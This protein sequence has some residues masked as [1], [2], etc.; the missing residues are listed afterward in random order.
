MKTILNEWRSFLAEDK[1]KKTPLEEEIEAVFAQQELKTGERLANVKAAA[2]AIQFLRGQQL[3]NQESYLNRQEFGMT[4]ADRIVMI[5]QDEN[6]FSEYFDIYTAV[7]APIDKRFPETSEKT[8]KAVEMIDTWS[9][10]NLEKQST[11][12]VRAKGANE[13]IAFEELFSKIGELEI[14]L[15]NKNYEFLKYFGKVSQWRTIEDRHTGGAASTGL[16]VLPEEATEEDKA[17]IGERYI[18]YMNHRNSAAYPMVKLAEEKF[19]EALK[20]ALSLWKQYPFKDAE[21]KQAYAGAVIRMQDALNQSESDLARIMMN[22]DEYSKHN[23]PEPK[24][25]DVES[26]IAKAKD[27]DKEAAKK[28]FDIL[29]NQGDKRWREMRQLM[30]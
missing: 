3:S 16:I 10:N 4:N 5:L 14:L 1:F 30:R 18:F 9:M 27:G 15:R 24:E 6:L 13:E 28:A 21:E 19:Q 8:F 2:H 11:P 22:P 26:L 20:K 17:Y 29:R 7:Q 12:S 23:K 25:E